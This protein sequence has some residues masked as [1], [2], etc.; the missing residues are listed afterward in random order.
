[1]RKLQ[2]IF[3]HR[4]GPLAVLALI[5]FTLSFITRVT[6]LIISWPN[7]ELSFLR[8]IGIF[9]IGFF[10][11]IIVWSFFAIPVALYCWLMKNSWYQKKWQRIPLFFLFFIITLILV[12]NVGGEIIFWDEFN[13]RYNFIAVD[14]LVYTTEVLGNIWESYNIPLIASAVIVAVAV[15]LFLV[16]I[17]LTASQQVSMRFVKRTVFFFLFMLIPVAGYFLVNNRFK[18]ISSNNYVNELGGN[19][20]MRLITIN[21]TPPEMTLQTLKYCVT[22]CRHPMQLL[23]MI[24]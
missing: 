1:M 15:V 20:T 2:S 9:F 12:L 22:C 16:R 19:G 4:F 6:L 17:K 21:F 13:V 10:Y 11:D 8:V 24:R 23:Q 5:V 18:N 3:K 14:Y 7:L